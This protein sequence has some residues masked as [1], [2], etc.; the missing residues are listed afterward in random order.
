MDGVR[1][2]LGFR[3]DLPRVLSSLNMFVVFSHLDGLGGFLIDAMA[4]GLPVAAADVGSARDLIT[5]RESGLLVPARSARALADA[6]LK[7]QFDRNLAARLA[8]RGRETVLE[9]YSAEAMARRIIGVYE[10]RA[11]RKGIKLA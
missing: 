5:H 2:Y 7:V 10:Y 8:S 4:S 9:K 1:Y 3:K 6:I 11:H